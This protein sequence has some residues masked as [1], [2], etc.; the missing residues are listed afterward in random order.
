MP[1]T[2]YKSL[3]VTLVCNFVT[4]KRHQSLPATHAGF[5]SPMMG[6][7]GSRTPTPQDPHSI[8]SSPTSSSSLMTSPA[9]GRLVTSP[10]PRRSRS[11]QR[12]LPE[13]G[14]E[15][16]GTSSS[17]LEQLK[18]QKSDQS[19]RSRTPESV[20]HHQRQ[21]SHS[22]KISSREDGGS[23]QREDRDRGR[24]GQKSSRRSSRKKLSAEDGYIYD[25]EINDLPQESHRLVHKVQSRGDVFERGYDDDPVDTSTF[26]PRPPKA[27]RSPL[28]LRKKSRD[29]LSVA[30]AD[31]KEVK[32][33]QFGS[34]KASRDLSLDRIRSPRASLKRKN[35]LPV[36]VTPPTPDGEAPPTAIDSDPVSTSTLSSFDDGISIL[37]AGSPPQ[38]I[39]K[40]LEDPE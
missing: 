21:R 6:R 15:Q 8:I 18:K 1:Y 39:L 11:R 31:K 29:D 20:Q 13:I 14:E 17:D 30:S 3:I 7:S 22:P 4:Q 19:L 36:E 9:P 23:G 12:K 2:L 32:G 25:P 5:L 38:L 40:G 26:S 28:L 16:H 10:A 34:S 37:N 24:M 35:N 27:R 33:L